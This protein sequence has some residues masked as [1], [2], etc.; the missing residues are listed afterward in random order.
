MKNNCT[1]DVYPHS[2]R[3]NPNKT[4]SHTH[5]FKVIQ[6]SVVFST[7]I[8]VEVVEYNHCDKMLS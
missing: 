5:P 1:S 7:D 2:I 4:S 3:M 6:L 8:F